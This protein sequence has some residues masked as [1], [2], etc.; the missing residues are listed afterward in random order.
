MSKEETLRLHLGGEQIKDGWKIVNT[1]GKPGV[2]F[3][4]DCRDLSQFADGSVGEIYASH[5]YQRLGYQKELP[6]AL[7]DAFRALKK[8]GVL[9]VSVPNMELLCQMYLTPGIHPQ[10]RF[11]VMRIMMGGQMDESD[12][13]KVMFDASLLGAL[14]QHAG[15]TKINRVISFGVF[16]DT[17]EL[18]V[19]GVPV[20]LNFVAVKEV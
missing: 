6:D 19:N 5:V 15:F 4:G 11:N 9:R 16:N 3:V 20:S 12:F 14:L 18:K 10:D 1:A 2:D 8:W 13:H 17:S 7:K